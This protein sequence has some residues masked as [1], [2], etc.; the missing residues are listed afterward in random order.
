MT[1][2]L[3]SPL[4]TTPKR[5]RN[6]ALARRLEAAGHEVYVP[7]EHPSPVKT[8]RAIFEKDRGGIDWAE[9]LVAIV[10][11]PDPDSGTSRGCG[12]AY[13]VGKP[14]VLLRNDLRAGGD[15]VDMPVN[16]MLVG[17]ADQVVNR[18]LATVEEAAEAVVTALAQHPAGHVR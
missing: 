8:A 15:A 12:Y 4:F 17:A 11:G 9:A 1:A 2:F 7:H 14:V 10:D 6:E 16:A 5:H 18:S 13:G 3:A